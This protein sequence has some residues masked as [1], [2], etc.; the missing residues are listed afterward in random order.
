MPYLKIVCKPKP[1]PKA[2]CSVK[3][4]HELLVK[5]IEV[6]VLDLN[7]GDAS[8]I[9]QF[10]TNLIDGS[11]TAKFKVGD[12]SFNF[13][14]FR[15]KV[16][17]T[18]VLD[19]TG[20]FLEIESITQHEEDSKLDQVPEKAKTTKTEEAQATGSIATIPS[21]QLGLG[22]I[23][24]GSPDLK[25]DNETIKDQKEDSARAL[26]AS[27]V[28]TKLNLTQK[29]GPVSIERILRNAALK[30]DPEDLQRLLPF[31]K[32]ID[33]PDPKFL[34][35]ALH[36]AAATIGKHENFKFLT[37]NN[38]S[39]YKVDDKGITAF[40]LMKDNPN[41]AYR[42]QFY[43]QSII[44]PVGKIN[45]LLIARV[46]NLLERMR[47][48]SVKAMKLRFVVQN[49]VKFFIMDKYEASA[50]HDYARFCLDKNC[51]EL[52][53]DTIAQLNDEELI[54]ILAHEIDHAFKA[55]TH[56]L[57][58]KAAEEADSNVGKTYHQT[59]LKYGPALIS[60][61][62][63]TEAF[64]ASAKASLEGKKFVF[65][66]L[67]PVLI[68]QNNGLN[69]SEDERELLAASLQVLVHYQP[70][71][72]TVDLDKELLLEVN[73]EL[74]DKINSKQCKLVHRVRSGYGFFCPIY[75]DTIADHGKVYTVKGFMSLD[76]TVGLQKAFA[77]VYELACLNLK[78]DE[79][80]SNDVQRRETEFHAYVAGNFHSEIMKFFFAETVK[81]DH[82]DDN[83][84]ELELATTA[85]M[86]MVFRY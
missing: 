30:G 62:P 86:R 19:D 67:Y 46:A 39:W 48:D 12:E 22:A 31:V 83:V 32:N 7:V 29:E 11:V 24:A 44:M 61:P 57:R 59:L 74:F 18:I 58:A 9:I 33:D 70:Q 49:G 77:F 82:D 52:Y 38:A 79:V 13:Q 66:T 51:I 26:I 14:N 16:C 8:P 28:M 36:W 23:A 76:P 47:R 35:T 56:L 80:Y 73:T 55:N 64:Q 75:I 85:A 25:V 34:R 71:H 53:I 21:H 43:K 50:D 3:F 84:A 63:V 40:E 42:Y 20:Q 60:F 81:D 2:I 69:L 65:R 68:K 6:R 10:S 72:Y 15:N 17:S 27:Q 54:K 4:Q 45:K 41:L 1:I 5:F 37:D 78:M